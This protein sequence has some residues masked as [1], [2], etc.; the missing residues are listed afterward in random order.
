MTI[1]RARDLLGMEIADASDGQIAEMIARDSAMLDA[2]L[3]V[4]DTVG[5]KQS[6]L[7]EGGRNADNG[8]NA[9]TMRTLH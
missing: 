5:Y 2:I 6:S 9:E 3:D 8:S 1:Q 4:F 7:T